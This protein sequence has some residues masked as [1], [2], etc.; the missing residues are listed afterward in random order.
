MDIQ[1]TRAGG[2]RATVAAA[3]F[4]IASSESVGNSHVETQQKKHC[5]RAGSPPSLYLQ[6]FILRTSLDASR[7]VL[8]FRRRPMSEI[9]KQG[10]A[11]LHATR[12]HTLEVGWREGCNLK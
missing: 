3:A 6:R 10:A 5:L 8:S 2:R 4:G 1:I 12:V 9:G 11:S 7:E